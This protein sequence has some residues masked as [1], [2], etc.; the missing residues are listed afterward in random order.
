MP[1]RAKPLVRATNISAV[2][3]LITE[4][5]GMVFRIAIA[6]TGSRRRG[7][8]VTRRVIRRALTVIGKWA[9]HDD[10][11]RWFAHHTVLAVRQLVDR[12]GYST[13]V[14]T[15]T[16]PE[17]AELAEAISDLP[18]QQREAFLLHH[19]EQFDLRR[20]STAMDC[21]TEAAKNHLAAAGRKLNEFGE[22]KVQAFISELPLALLSITPDPLLIHQ[23]VGRQVRR[24]IWPRRIVRTV[25]WIAVIVGVWVA[26]HYIRRV[27]GQ[28]VW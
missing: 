26:V 5:Y 11:A 15:T 1:R 22:E 17:L 23:R 14:F 21:S 7:Q 6:S 19:G 28:V 9:S 8:A 12:R 27:W 24:Y 25:I 20:I 4:H 2:T 16:K 13:E 18:F 10:A 3:R